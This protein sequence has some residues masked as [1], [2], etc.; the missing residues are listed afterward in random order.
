MTYNQLVAQLK[1]FTNRPE[2]HLQ[3]TLDPGLAL[4][5]VTPPLSTRVTAIILGQGRTAETIHVPRPQRPQ[6]IKH[7]LDLD[8][9]QRLADLVELLPDDE[10]YQALKADID[11]LIDEFVGSWRPGTGPGRRDETKRNALINALAQVFHEQS[12]WRRRYQR[13]V[14]EY[15]RAYRASLTAFLVFVLVANRLSFPFDRLIRLRLVHSR[16]RVPRP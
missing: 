14:A 5:V 10:R 2:C 9:D 16:F 8:N 13:D 7:K 1:V 15:P 12:N 3:W 11:R 4:G 6:R